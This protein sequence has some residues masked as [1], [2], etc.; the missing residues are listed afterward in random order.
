MPGEIVDGDTL[1]L[2]AAQ[3]LA[4]FHRTALTYPNPAPRPGIP[5]L[6]D[7]N[8]HSNHAWHWPDVDALLNSTPATAPKFWQA[9]GHAAHTI[10]AR[11]TQIADERTACAR[12]V[13]HLIASQRPIAFGIIHDDFYERNLLVRHRRITALLDWDGCHPDWLMM[14]VSNAVWE[15][16]QDQP[17]HT[18]DVGA[19]RAFIDTYLAAGGPITCNELDLLIPFIRFRRVLETLSGLQNAIH[20]EQWDA[21]FADYAVHTLVALENLRRVVL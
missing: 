16:C 14:D 4:R 5:P 8:W 12:W 10:I 19:A 1:R 2:P 15:F 18:L 13:G 9:S 20:G 17:A 3:L 6:R 7:W 11:R 21:G